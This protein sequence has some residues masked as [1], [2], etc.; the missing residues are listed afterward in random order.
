MVRRIGAVLSGSPQGPVALAAVLL[1]LMT[2]VLLPLGHLQQSSASSFMPALLALVAGFDLLSVILLVGG[3]RDRGDKRLLLMAATFAWSLVIMGGYAL[4]FPGAVSQTPPLA[5]TASTAPYLYVI[6]HTTFPVMLALSCYPWPG[7]F[8]RPTS[9]AA[10]LRMVA[11]VLVCVL[12]AAFTLAA[13]VVMSSEGL[14][15]LIHGTDTSRMTSL[16]APIALP[17]V[18]AALVLCHRGARDQTGPERWVPIVV[19]TCLCD[20]VLT[21]VSGHRYSLGW[22]AGRTLTLLA[23]GLLVVSM[24]AIFRR[25]SALAERDAAHDPLTNLLNRRSASL[26]LDQLIA[27]ARRLDEP[28]SLVSVD[29]DHFKSINDTHGH[30]VGDTVLAAVAEVLRSTCRA[31]DVVARVGGEEF[32]IV[33]PGTDEPGAVRVAEKVRRAISGDLVRGLRE[34]VTA[35]LGLTTFRLDDHDQT[36]MLRRADRAMYHVKQTGRDRVATAPLSPVL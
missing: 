28:L 9:P 30:E 20:L 32:L 24:L 36:D 22:Y 19:L 2:L 18:L 29:L 6:W 4:A 26:A 23:S 12:I 14:P 34:P 27:R 16:T 3:Y 33:L 21:Y 25:L 17:A 5:T 1:V 31:S 15:A 11:I 10:R 13:V 35:S 7:R 8:S